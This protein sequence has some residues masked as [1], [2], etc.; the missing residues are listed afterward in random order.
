MSIRQGNNIIAGNTDGKK[1]N[2]YMTNCITEIPQD[3]KLETNTTFILDKED[4]F[5]Y[6]LYNESDNDE[7]DTQWGNDAYYFK[8]DNPTLASIELTVVVRVKQKADS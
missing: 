5:T 3:I 8:E 6:N 7:L 1:F 4:L 2:A